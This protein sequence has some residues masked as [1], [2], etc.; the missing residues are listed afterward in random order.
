[1]RQAQGKNKKC[2]KSKLKRARRPIFGEY[3]LH[4]TYSDGKLLLYKRQ[5][6]SAALSRGARG[7]KISFG[8]KENLLAS[9]E[10]MLCCW[11]LAILRAMAS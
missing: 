1:M 3:V 10:K 7:G 5:F 4:Y 8:K 11:C 2:R 9:A 6:S